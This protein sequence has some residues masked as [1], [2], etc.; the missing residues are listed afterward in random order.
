MTALPR[1]VYDADRDGQPRVLSH[2]GRWIGWL[3]ADVA[4]IAHFRYALVHL[5]ASRLSVR[6]QRSALGFL[7]T[8]LTPLLNLSVQAVIFSMLLNRP[9]R[10]YAVYLF[11]GMLPWQF[12]AATLSNGARSMI[13]NEDLIRKMYVP[14]L[15]FPLATMLGHAIDLLFATVALFLLLQVIRAPIHPQLVV[16]PVAIALVMLFAMGL[17]LILMVLNTYYR[18]VEQVIPVA[19]QAWYFASP[20]LWHVDWAGERAGQ[21]ARLVSLNPMAHLLE[22]FHAI[23][24]DGV[25]P[26]AAQWGSAG[27]LAGGTMLLGYLVYKQYEE[28][29][30]YRL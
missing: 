28:R 5:I 26:S 22:P 9:L 7:W 30:I 6:Y 18:D 11:A 8:L 12:F 17:A 20:V 2:P 29:L 19:L 25:W 13:T 21:L 15:L 23:F 16:L 3:R 4:T 14:K 24:S 10:T 1:R 27:L